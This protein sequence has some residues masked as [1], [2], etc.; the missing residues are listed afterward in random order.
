MKIFLIG[1]PG[2]GKSTLGKQLA[3]SLM[4]NFIDL[5]KEIE[6]HEGKSVAEIFSQSGED[7]FRMI[8]SRLLGHFASSSESFVMAT[9][10]GAPCFYQGI[11]TINDSG[12]SIF[13]DTPLERLVERTSNKSTRPLLSNNTDDQLREKLKQI[14][15]SRLPIYEQARIRLAAPDLSQVLKSLA[16]RTD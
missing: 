6:N 3:G 8:E 11:K 13:L 7:H 2:A 14:R 4:T 9:G 16:M 5:D 15:E 1:M 12:V 10:G